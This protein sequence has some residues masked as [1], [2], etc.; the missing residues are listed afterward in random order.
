MAKSVV[1]K[2]E[3]IEVLLTIA[4]IGLREIDAKIGKNF[5]PAIPGQKLTGIYRIVG[6]RV[7]T[8]DY[9]GE[10]N[11]P[12]PIRGYRYISQ[13]QFRY[14][15]GDNV[16]A[17]FD[18]DSVFAADVTITLVIEYHAPVA[19]KYD[20]AFLESW[21]RTNMMLHAWP[22]WREALQSI[23]GRMNLPGTILPLM[24]FSNQ[25]PAKNTAGSPK[26]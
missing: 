3:N 9:K 23:L 22:Y 26:I 8:V 7:D 25:Q 2:S 4:S 15:V 17:N 10:N 14:V 6:G 16:E 19:I 21:G 20:N 13:F 24:Q 11:E 12:A 1:P 5:D 18:D